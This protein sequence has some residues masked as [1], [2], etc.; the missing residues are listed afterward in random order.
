[1]KA[2]ILAG[3]MGIRLGQLTK[4]MQKTMI[5][6]NGKPVLQHQ[7]EFLKKNGITDLILSIGYLG[8]QIQNFFGDGKNFGVKIDYVVEDEPLGTAGPLKL[9]KNFLKEAFVMINGDTLIDV[10][11]DEVVNFHKKMGGLATIMLVESEETES[12]G[13]VKLDGEKIVEFLE[14]PEEDERRLINGG[15]YIVEPGLVDMVPEGR[16]MIEKDI[17][18][19]LASQGKLFGWTGNVK[20]LDMGTPERLEKAIK[21]WKPEL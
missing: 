20:I 14:K 15:M 11:I 8:K 5:D 18:P 1:M 6:V 19:K 16:C 12:R 9:A 13:I 4:M 17:F 21:E 10:K 7:L 3:G 2:L